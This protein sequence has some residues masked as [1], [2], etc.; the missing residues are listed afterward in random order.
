MSRTPGD[1]AVKRMAAP[2]DGGC[3]QDPD[4]KQFPIFVV[5]RDRRDLPCHAR[6]DECPTVHLSGG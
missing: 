4:F 5:E 2:A 6:E 1:F 3:V